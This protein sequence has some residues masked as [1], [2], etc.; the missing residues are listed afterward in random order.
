MK[1]VLEEPRG[2]G[3]EECRNKT[4]GMKKRMWCSLRSYT[5]SGKSEPENLCQPV[6]HSAPSSSF[7]L[8][9]NL[10]R[11]SAELALAAS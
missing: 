2:N 11:R 6:H 7:T 9:L 4:R 5:W 8:S 3:N 1:H 10:P